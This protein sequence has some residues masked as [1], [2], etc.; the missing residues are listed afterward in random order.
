M[1]ARAISSPSRRPP[2]RLVMI[3]AVHISQALAPIARIAGLDPSII[4]PRTAFATPE[5]F[6]DVAGHRRMAGR[7]AWTRRRSTA[8]PRSRC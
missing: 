8:T 4:D 1:T 5:R 7:G 6:P 2:V 3:G